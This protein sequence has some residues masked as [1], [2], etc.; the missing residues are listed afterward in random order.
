[1]G[2]VL[3]RGTKDRPSWYCKYRDLDGAWKQRATKQTTKAAAMRYVAEIAARVARG[4]IG[5]QEPS[6]EEQKAK[7]LTVGELAQRFLAEYDSPRLK[8]RKRYLEGAGPWVRCRLL[9]YQLASLPVMDV[10]KLHVAMCRDELRK[11]GFQPT[12]INTSLHFLSRVFTWCAEAE[13]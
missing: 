6:Q 11:Q 1:M 3:N 12:T 10:R 8:D 7:T 2:Y 13:M 4:R 5:I 9:P